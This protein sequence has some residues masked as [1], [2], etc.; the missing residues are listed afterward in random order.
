MSRHIAF[1]GGVG[2]CL[3]CGLSVAGESR[4]RIILRPQLDPEAASIELFEGLDSGAIAAKMM[5]RNEQGGSIF[6]ENLSGEPL[7]IEMPEAFVGVQVLPQIDLQIPVPGNAFPIGPQNNQQQGQ[8]QPVG[9]GTSGGRNGSSNDTIF[10]NNSFFSVPAERVARIEYSSVC[11]KHG[12]VTPRRGNVYRLVRVEE[13][14]KDPRLA[15]LLKRVA[16]R[17][18]EQAALQAAAWHLANEMSW[19]ELAAKRF[20]RLN[21]P[22]TRWFSAATLRTA[23]SI[24]EQIDIEL[25]AGEDV[26][27]SEDSTQ[28][29]PSRLTKLAR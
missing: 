26:L 24:V 15:E 10:G 27:P 25:A 28:E 14:S 7:T 23:H 13:F 11:L 20:R 16:G 18:G 17:Q 4:G 5:P 3:L 1:L 2:L 6:V 22:D 29:K 21:A 12:A 9:G 19:E 8:N